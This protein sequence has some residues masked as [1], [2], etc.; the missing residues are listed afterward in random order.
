MSLENFEEIEALG[1]GS[2]SVVHKV[3]RKKDGKIYA[4]KKCSIGSLKQKEKENSL[5]EIRILASI[6]DPCIISYKE[7]FFENDNLWLI[8]DYADD[9]DLY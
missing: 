2:Y 9:G 4:M 1:A 6:C 7:A 3:K 5:N 8:M